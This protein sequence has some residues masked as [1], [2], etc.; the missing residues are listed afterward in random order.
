MS[1]SVDTP[2]DNEE[3]KVSNDDIERVKGLRTKSSQPQ[4]NTTAFS[5]SKLLAVTA[6]MAV[7]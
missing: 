4:D 2:V 5:S 1:E 6:I 7:A 3:K